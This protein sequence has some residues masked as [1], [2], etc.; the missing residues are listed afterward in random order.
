MPD[1]AEFEAQV[2]RALTALSPPEDLLVAASAGADSTALVGALS[3]ARKRRAFR[4]LKVVVGH[5]RHD[6]RAEAETAADWAQVR[7]LAASFGFEAAVARVSVGPEGGLEQAAREARYQALEGLALAHGCHAVLTAHTAT[8]QAETVLLRLARGAGARGLGGMAADRPLGQVRLLR[9]LLGLTRDQT[10]AY[11]EARRLPFRDDPT[12]LD[13]RPRV[14]VRTE[15]LP[16][17]ESLAPG[18]V[19]RIAAAAQRLQD[20]EAL[21]SAQA[22]QAGDTIE[23]L[24]ALPRPVRRR[25]LAGWCERALGTRRRVTADHL[26]ALERLVL[27]RRGQVALPADRS[28]QRVAIIGADQRLRVVEMPRANRSPQTGHRPT[29]APPDVAP[30]GSE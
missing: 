12:N 7:S 5:V 26:E 22:V 16:V 23:A 11:C 6:L 30:E 17:L 13:P 3:A 9:P 18:A 10:R 27:D 8:D 20:D 21:L 4:R 29:Q 15:V 28:T 1:A 24:A 2:A 14:R 19:L 25:A